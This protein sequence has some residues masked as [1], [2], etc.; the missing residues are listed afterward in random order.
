HPVEHPREVLELVDELPS[1]DA[2]ETEDWKPGPGDEEAAKTGDN[3]VE[4]L[5]ITDPPGTG[6]PTPENPA[7][8]TRPDELIDPESQGDL[9]SLS[10]GH[11]A[12]AG[13][14]AV[15]VHPMLAALAESDGPFGPALS[16]TLAI[17]RATRL[18]P[19]IQMFALRAHLVDV[20]GSQPTFDVVADWVER[21]HETTR[22]MKR[23]RLTT[24]ELVAYV[25]AFS[26]PPEPESSRSAAAPPG[27][28]PAADGPAAPGGHGG[29]AVPISAGTSPESV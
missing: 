11:E 28:L 18:E 3:P 13:L 22:P 12:D 17:E 19:R 27:G 10:T 21:A 15:D 1:D 25:A 16:S 29:H 6:K 7:P 23:G 4:A 2:A 20:L 26:S 8:L 5:G 9:T 14:P 24:G